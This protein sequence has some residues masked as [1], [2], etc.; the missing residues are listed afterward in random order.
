VYR[1]S[2]VAHSMRRVW[3]LGAPHA[4]EI[5]FVFDTLRAHY[6]RAVTPADEV[7]SRTLQ[8]YWVAFARTGRPDPR[9][10]PAWPRYQPAADRLMDFT[11]R[12][13]IF[14]PDPYRQRIDLVQRA[15]LQKPGT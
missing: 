3:T 14:E 10:E 15:G 5:P 1:F 8:R 12:G 13:P 11:A 2:Y 9:G 6:G 7:M 4:S